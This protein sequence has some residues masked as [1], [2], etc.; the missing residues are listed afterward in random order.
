MILYFSGTGNCKY[1]AERIAKG[2]GEEARSIIGLEPNIWLSQGEMFGLVHPVYWWALPVPVREFYENLNIISEGENYSFIVTTYGTTPGSCA[3]EAKR[4]LTK[5]NFTLDAAFSIQM[6]DNWTPMFDL[7]DPKK[8][9]G[10]LDRA[11]KQIEK[12]LPRIR[13]RERGNHSTPRMPY[14]THNFCVGKLDEERR[15]KHFYLEDGC[16]GCGLCARE[17]PVQ[18]IEMKDKKP[19]WKRSNAP[20]A[21]ATCTTARS[22]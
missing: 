4:I 21:C 5:K 12:M 20:Y 8:V 16:I 3:E 1:V 13:T 2:Y 9:A 15:T 10:Q 17:C 14:F 6:P 18:A 22:L 11:E 19:V 7:S